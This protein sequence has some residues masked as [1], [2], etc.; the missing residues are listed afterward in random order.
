MT[1]P[2]VK[3]NPK[4]HV[5]EN[6]LTTSLV[7]S[8]QQTGKR[9]TLYLLLGLAIMIFCGAIGAGFYLNYTQAYMNK[10]TN[11]CDEM[12]AN[13]FSLD[14]KIADI[15]EKV[16]KLK[17][18]SIDDEQQKLLVRAAN[19][20]HLL[21]FSNQINEKLAKFSSYS[22][23]ISSLREFAEGKYDKELK[24]IEE[25]HDLAIISDSKL[26]DALKQPALQA[27]AEK[28]KPERRTWSEKI[29]GYF[30]D[31][32]KIRKTADVNLQKSEHQLMT[33]AHDKILAGQYPEAVIVL[34]TVPHMND[35]IAFII[36]VLQA[37]I[38]TLA[39]TK[40]IMAEALR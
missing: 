33:E 32:F 34:N 1:K 6:I 16:D 36:K 9:I 20:Y 3:K 27:E 29:K 5:E 13:F 7:A 2:K 40:K 14:H 15:G 22:D 35:N 25:A 37:R 4:S 30:D 23:S 18:A 8:R 26:I 11:I 24:D 38:I 21:L 17:V 12:K 19:K 39:A 28:L 31:S 10:K